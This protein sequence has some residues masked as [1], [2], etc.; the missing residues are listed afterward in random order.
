MNSI[1]LGNIR[2]VGGIKMDYKQ[3]L[4]GTAFKKAKAL[5]KVIED[6]KIKPN[7]TE[8]NIEKLVLSRCKAKVELEGGQI[9]DY[10]KGQEWYVQHLI[11]LSKLDKKALLQMCYDELLV[12]NSS[13][14]ELL[15]LL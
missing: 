4:V 3:E 11:E 13:F 10:V 12:E 1:R 6:L 5:L 2:A 14:D 9:T 8:K 7:M 15:E